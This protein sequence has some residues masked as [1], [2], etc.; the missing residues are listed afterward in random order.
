MSRNGRWQIF[1]VGDE[2]NITQTRFSTPFE[3]SAFPSFPSL[4]SQQYRRTANAGVRWQLIEMKGKIIF[5][6]ENHVLN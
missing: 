1:C 6:P 4:S 5:T 2:K 3:N